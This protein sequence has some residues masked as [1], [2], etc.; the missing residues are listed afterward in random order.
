MEGMVPVEK[1][2]PAEKVYEAWTAVEDGHA[3]L[4]DDGATCTVV[5][6]DGARRYTVRRETGAE[7]RYETWVFKTCMLT[8]MLLLM[9]P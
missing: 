9:A 5:S 8:G 3:R 6:S 1:L 2:P 4:G 7:G